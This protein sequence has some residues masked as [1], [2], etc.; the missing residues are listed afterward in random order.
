M[1]LSVA[2]VLDLVQFFFPL[3]FGFYNLLRAIIVCVRLRI[4]LWVGGRSWHAT[5][6]NME[7]VL[8]QLPIYLFCTQLE[9]AFTCFQDEM[10]K[11]FSV[12]NKLLYFDIRKHTRV[13]L[14][15][16]SRFSRQVWSSFNPENGWIGIAGQKSHKQ[17]LTEVLFV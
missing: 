14:C 7:Q 5:E 17:D 16:V 13:M 12:S 8:W 15:G 11:S 9:G 2:L 6:L 1:L 3:F 4:G 10:L